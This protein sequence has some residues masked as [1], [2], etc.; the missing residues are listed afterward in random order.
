MT[1][2][3][4]RLA[5]RRLAAVGGQQSH[6]EAKQQSGPGAVLDSA[7][8]RTHHLLGS[9]SRGFYSGPAQLTQVGA[10]TLNITILP[11]TDDPETPILIPRGT[12]RGLW[13]DQRLGSSDSKKGDGEK[14]EDP[15]DSV[16][17]KGGCGELP[18]PVRTGGGEV[19]AGGSPPSAAL[20]SS[21]KYLM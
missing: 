1:H 12:S 17:R 14:G 9:A 8:H 21:C 18:W 2:S 11:G 6:A 7:P 10:Q 13:P 5:F 4:Q 15:L 16:T 20:S 3:S 19:A